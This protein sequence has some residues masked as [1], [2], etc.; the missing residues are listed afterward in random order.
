MTAKRLVKIC[1]KKGLYDTP[2]YNDSLYLNHEGFDSIA[3]LE[4]Y[5]NIKSLFLEG[6]SIITIENIGHLQK[7]RGLYLRDN[8]IKSISN[9]DGLTNLKSL[10]LANNQIKVIENMS[11]LKRLETLN[12][13]QNLISTVDA[14]EKILDNQAI[15]TLNLMGNKIKSEEEGMK[16]IKLLSNLPNLRA[17]YL[18]GNECINQMNFYR[19]HTISTIRTLTFL[20][21]R[22]VFEHERRLNDA[23]IRGGAKAE[24]LEKKLIQKE[25]NE[26]RNLTRKSFVISCEFL[27]EI[28]SD[29]DEIF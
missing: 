3:N 8:L 1:R 25:K 16:L 6:N 10:D 19:K 24:D 4:P 2:E 22:P 12:L 15:S 20:D 17:L 14:L 11:H 26:K 13:E 7:L 29:F 5:H 9:L 27:L 28:I 23:W 21:D 18:K